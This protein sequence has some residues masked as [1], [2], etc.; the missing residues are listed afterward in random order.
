MGWRDVLERPRGAEAILQVRAAALCD[1]DRLVKHLRT[2]PGHPCTRRPK[3]RKTKGAAEYEAIGL[4][5]RLAK[6][7]PN[8]AQCE[9]TL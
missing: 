2:R 3:I 4:D 7:R 6:T 9:R 1:D 5:A 8:V